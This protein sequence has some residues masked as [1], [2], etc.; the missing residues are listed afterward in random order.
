MREHCC[1]TFKICKNVGKVSSFLSFSFVA[2]IYRFIFTGRSLREFSFIWAASVFKIFI[3]LVAHI[4]GR[5]RKTKLRLAFVRWSLESCSNVV[6]QPQPDAQPH[7]MLSLSST[8]N[9]LVSVWC[10]PAHLL[11]QREREREK[12]FIVC[13]VW[14]RG[15]R[16]RLEIL[17]SPLPL[18][19]RAACRLSPAAFKMK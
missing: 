13:P 11:I 10:F 9:P 3:S 2:S 7:S 16:K 19:R 4:L 18:F 8:W 5:T 12:D 17:L 15:K 1:S 14:G 6:F